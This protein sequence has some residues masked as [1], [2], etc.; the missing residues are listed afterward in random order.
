MKGL[1]SQDDH[2]HVNALSHT[3]HDAEDFIGPGVGFSK[4]KK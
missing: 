4:G 2:H 1:Q 3:L